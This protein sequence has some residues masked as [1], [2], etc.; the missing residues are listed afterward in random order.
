MSAG[1][2]YEANIERARVL[3]SAGR[4]HDCA[5]YAQRAIAADPTNADGYYVLSHAYYDMRNRNREALKAIDDALAQ[6]PNRSDLHSWRASILM[7]LSRYRPSIRAAN[8]ALALDPNDIVAYVARSQS[9]RRIGRRKEAEAD[10]RHAL[11]IDPANT[12]ARLILAQ[13]MRLDGRLEESGI[14]VKSLL[15]EVPRNPL[16]LANA[17]WLAIEA[18]NFDVAEEYV[19]SALACD[20]N[21]G[22]ARRTWFEILRRRIFF[23]RWERKWRDA[24]LNFTTSDRTKKKW[25]WF[26]FIPHAGI[27]IACIFGLFFIAG[28]FLWAIA[29]SM[30]DYMISLQ[31]TTRMLLTKPE[32][33]LTLVKGLIVVPF[34]LYLVLT[35]DLLRNSL[36]FV[37][38]TTVLILCIQWIVRCCRR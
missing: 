23:Y 29:R 36:I 34:F 4:F 3:Y 27:I 15:A 17:G 22:F 14:M 31:P 1:P 13:I 38:A 24:V 16:A 10:A 26:I 5:E 21:D 37:G 12:V 18:G 20:P 25:W 28:F 19:K 32:W 8:E 7:M 35:V 11:S 30:A 9:F 33:N 2:E 6:E